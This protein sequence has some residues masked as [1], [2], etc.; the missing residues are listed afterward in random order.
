VPRKTESRDEEELQREIGRRVRAARMQAG[1]TQ[2][3]AAATAGI[4][5]RRWQ[6][7]ENGA[8]N[9]TVRTLAR[10]ATA[11]GSTFWALLAPPTPVEEPARRGK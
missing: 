5:W 2:E 7:I 4:D 1:L 6:R 9:P 8:V 11:I 3:D 10:V